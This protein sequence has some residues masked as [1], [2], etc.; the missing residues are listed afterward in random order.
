MFRGS[1]TFYEAMYVVGFAIMMVY[2]IGNYKRY[3]LVK[4]KAIVYT[5]YTYVCGIVGAL[6]MGMIYNKVHETLGIA[7][8]SNVAIMGAVVFTPILFFLFPVSKEERKNALDMITP[9]VL[10]ILACAKFGCFINGCCRG[11]TSEFGICYREETVKHFPIQAVEVLIMLIILFVTQFY[12]KKSKHYTVGTAYPITFAV[13]CVSRFITE[14]FRYYED[15]R[16]KDIACSMTFWQLLCIV[17]FVVFVLTV[18]FM[19]L[20]SKKN[21]VSEEN[22]E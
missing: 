18:V 14:Y 13:Y 15:P 1:S 22:N 9:G 10:E 11:V 7:T 6:I 3:N 12:F 2:N 8:Y 21:L 17:V 4:K 20:R 5:L 19:K 16:Q